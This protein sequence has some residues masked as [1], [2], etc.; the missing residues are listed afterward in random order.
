MSRS[1]YTFLAL[2]ALGLVALVI[3]KGKAVLPDAPVVT[4]GESLTPANSN[5]TKGP[6]YTM[7]NQPWYFGPDVAPFL[8][9]LSNRA[10]L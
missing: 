4:V 7:Y 5:F 9:R 1:E 8:P 10:T 3:W 2:L 6:A